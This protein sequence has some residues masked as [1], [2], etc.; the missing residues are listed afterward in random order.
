MLMKALAFETFCY[1]PKVVSLPTPTPGPDELKI[2]VEFSALDTGLDA[3]LQKTEVGRFIHKYTDPLQLGWHFSGTVVEVGSLVVK[4]AVE[5][6]V[7][8][9]LQYFPGQVQGAFSEYI[10]IKPEECAVYDPEKI[11]KQE[12]AAVAT[13]YITSLQALRDCAKLQVGTTSTTSCHCLVIGGGGGVG[14]AA[15]QLAKH[16][17]GAT[18]T[19]VCSEKDRT[20]VM[21][22][23]ADH[24]FIRDGKTIEEILTSCEEKYD[25]I[26][27]TPTVLDPAFANKLLSDDGKYIATIPKDPTVPMVNAESNRRDLELLAKWLVDGR[28]HVPIDSTFCVKD[29]ES[30]IRRQRQSDKTGRVVI[31]VDGGW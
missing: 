31:Q 12:A 7:F 5:D 10:V 29:M 15:V 4:N 18:T 24:I 11:S 28:I 30:A 19:A 16:V 1:H 8:G 2:R 14:L 3:V 17:F 25:C 9:F 13:E 27:D 20:R 23:G 22:A 21:N 6:A 26:F